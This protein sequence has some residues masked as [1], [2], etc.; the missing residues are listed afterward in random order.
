M[1]RFQIV[2]A[3]LLVVAMMTALSVAA[4]VNPQ[5]TGDLLMDIAKDVLKTAAGAALGYAMAVALWL[6]WERRKWGGWKLSV[7]NRNG[8]EI[9]KDLPPSVVKKWLEDALSDFGGF[10]DLTGSINRWPACGLVTVDADECRRLGALV[11]DEKI[12]LLKFDYSKLP[13]AASTGTG[14]R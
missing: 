13:A 7:V 1:S 3:T 4:A 6:G 5:A 11:V 12:K 8:V 2:I 14:P 10:R 9:Q